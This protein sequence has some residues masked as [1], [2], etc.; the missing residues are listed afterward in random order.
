MVNI[1]FSTVFFKRYN[2]KIHK[3]KLSLHIVFSKI[4]ISLQ[5]TCAEYILNVCINPIGL[6]YLLGK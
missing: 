2:H 5:N 3:N 4:L 6:I 1:L